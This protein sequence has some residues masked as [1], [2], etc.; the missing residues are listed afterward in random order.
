[1]GFQERMTEKLG[2][3]L[4]RLKKFPEYP[5]TKEYELFREVLLN[6]AADADRLDPRLG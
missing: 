1:M 2:D 6:Y 3:V 5:P 4:G